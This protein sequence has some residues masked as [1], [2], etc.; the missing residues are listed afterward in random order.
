MATDFVQMSLFDLL[1]AVEVPEAPVEA[2]ACIVS[3][4]EKE[5]AKRDSICKEWRSCEHGPICMDDEINT[6]CF[7]FKDEPD[8]LPIETGKNADVSLAELCRRCKTAHTHCSDCC[9]HCKDT[10][11]AGQRCRWPEVVAPEVDEQSERIFSRDQLK[12]LDV[13]FSLVRC[14]REEK[15][16]DLVTSAQQERGWCSIGPFPTY[17]AAERKLKELKD[18][19][20]IETDRNGKIIMTGWNRP[21]GLLKEGFEFY[22]CYGLHEYDQGCCI[23]QGSKNWSNW[24]K[25]KDPAELEKAWSEL[26]NGD[27]KALEG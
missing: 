3:E 23:K 12:L 5:A 21:G 10:C 24:G 4:S 2:P 19:G 27:S 13:G 18:Q 17:A 20:C 1:E 9:A 7:C 25:Y 26:M 22:R 15:R 11:N 16:I 6:G 8:K 14:T